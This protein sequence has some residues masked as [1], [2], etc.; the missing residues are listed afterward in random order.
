VLVTGF[1]ASG[2]LDVATGATM[3]TVIPEILATY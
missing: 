3:Q 1:V 2:D